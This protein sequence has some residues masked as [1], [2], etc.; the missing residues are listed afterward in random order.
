MNHTNKIRNKI[1][2]VTIS[3]NCVSEIEKTITS[4]LS[5]DYSNVEYIVIDGGSNDGTKEVIERYV[6]GIDYWVSEPDG[7][8]YN[9]MN[10]GIDVA[11]GEWIIFMNSGDVFHDHEV[12]SRV[13]AKQYDSDVKVIY[14]NVNMVFPNGRILKKSFANLKEE[15]KVFDICHQGAFTRLNVLKQI[16]YDESYRIM[17]DLDSFRKI[18]E[19]GGVFEFVNVVIANFDIMGVSSTKPFL[20]CKE[21]LRLRKIDCY[22]RNGLKTISRALI[23]FLSIKFLPKAYFEKIRFIKLSRM[24]MFSVVK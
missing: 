2:I 16:H 4:V 19:N 11:T 20:S 24:K 15:C 17:A 21:S 14:G 8:I 18:K 9:A 6:D 3:Y 13:F 7:G 23:N 1:S 10:K 12:L 22:S 5:L